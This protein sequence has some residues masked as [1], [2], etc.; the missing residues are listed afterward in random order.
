MHLSVILWAMVGWTLFLSA[1]SKSLAS[2]H[3][4]WPMM[5]IQEPMGPN[6]MDQLGLISFTPRGILAK[7][8]VRLKFFTLP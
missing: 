2:C 1:P 3:T 7:W 5:M 6:L 4:M 8:R